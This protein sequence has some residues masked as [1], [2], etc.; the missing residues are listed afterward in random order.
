MPHD[1]G[2][3]DWLVDLSPRETEVLQGMADGLSNEEIG[4]RLHIAYE[5][6]RSHVRH[7]LVKLDVKNRAHAVATG[8]REDL[9]T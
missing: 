1:G 4:K 7:I 5:T 8:F 9:I 2:G 3:R 6:V